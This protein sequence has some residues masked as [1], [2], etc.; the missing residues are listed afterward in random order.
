MEKGDGVVAIGHEAVGFWCLFLL[1]GS[2]SPLLLQFVVKIVHLLQI[3][4]GLLIFF[5]LDIVVDNSFACRWCILPDEFQTFR[6]G[7][8]SEFAAGA[9]EDFLYVVLNAIDTCNHLAC[10]NIAK[11]TK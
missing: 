6:A 11:L 10:E 3:C 2:S 7:V 9:L 4:S 8:S 5:L 1:S